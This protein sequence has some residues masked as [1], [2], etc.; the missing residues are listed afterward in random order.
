MFGC[1][2]Q[3]ASLNRFCADGHTAS[4]FTPMV[5]TVSGTHQ[6]TESYLFVF[7]KLTRLCGLEQTVLL[8]ACFISFLKGSLESK[9]PGWFIHPVLRQN[10]NE[11]SKVKLWQVNTERSDTGMF[12]RLVAEE[13]WGAGV[14]LCIHTLCQTMFCFVSAFFFFFEP[15]FHL[16]TST[17]S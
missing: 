16:N 4:D 13:G 9:T 12:W 14:S 11:S 3:K 1:C 17:E 8:S 2:W 15:V 10:E 6:I 5:G 7:Q